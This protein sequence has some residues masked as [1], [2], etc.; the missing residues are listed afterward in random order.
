MKIDP[1]KIMTLAITGL[2]IIQAGSLLLSDLIGI[3]VLKIGQAIMIITL[4]LGLVILT[5]VS[6]NFSRLK[7]EDFFYFVIV[8]G[9]MYAIYIYLPNLEYFKEMFSVFRTGAFSVIVP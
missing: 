4:G 6:F 7:K 5:S 9:I 2:I 3:P 1:K 8:A